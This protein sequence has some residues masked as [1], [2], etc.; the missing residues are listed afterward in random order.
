MRAWSSYDRSSGTRLGK[1]SQPICQ[2]TLDNDSTGSSEGDVGT[3]E[4]NS[5]NSVLA[6]SPMVSLFTTDETGGTDLDTEEGNLSGVNTDRAPT[7]AQIMVFDRMA[8]LREELRKKKI[9]SLD[10]AIAATRQ[11]QTGQASQLF[12]SAKEMAANFA[13]SFQ[14]PAYAIAVFLAEQ[15]QQGKAAKS[16]QLYRSTIGEIQ[17]GENSHRDPLVA[18]IL[19]EVARE[20]PPINLAER[21]VDI[22]SIIVHYKKTVAS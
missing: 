2:S 18:K 6:I 10:T 3:S 13:P 8:Y 9:A 22:T 20:A 21:S 11:R 14:A 15:H 16:C 7:E 1:G 5:S 17:S 4:S 19:R 12:F